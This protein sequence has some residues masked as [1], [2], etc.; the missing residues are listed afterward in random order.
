[1]AAR[2]AALRKELQDKQRQLQEQGKGSAELQAIIDEMNRVETDLVNKRLTNQLL[3]RQ[4]DILTRLLEAEK[5]ERQQDEDERRES[6]AA[7]ELERTLPPALE[8]YLRERAAQT[9]LYREVSP[10]L[11]PYYR[12]LVERYFEE[13]K[14]GEGR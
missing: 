2:Q 14:A 3:E 9:D 11:K 10:E 13:L 1:M 6:T 5:A 12:R 7:R 8:E 4:Q